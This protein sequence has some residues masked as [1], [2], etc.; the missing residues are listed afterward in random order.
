MNPYSAQAEIQTPTAAYLRNTPVIRRDIQELVEG[1]FLADYLYREGAATPSG[2][3]HY[4]RQLL[5]NVVNT[6]RSVQ[7]VEELT[8]FPIL[9]AEQPAI[10]A[11]YAEKWGGAFLFSYEKQ[12]QDRRDLL[13]D[14][15]IRLRTA[16]LSKCNLVAITTFNNDPDRNTYA[17]AAPWTDKTNGQ[18]IND[19]MQAKV[20]ARNR[21]L[22]YQPDTGI[23]HELDV[24]E[25]LGFD[26]V[27]DRLPREDRSLN[28]FLSQEIN[29]LLGLDWVVAEDDEI[30]RGNVHII[31]RQRA[32]SVHDAKPF[33]SRIVDKPELEGTLIMAGRRT[34]P[35]VTDPKA[36]TTI[37]GVSV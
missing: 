28:P 23:I 19:I 6:T 21:K 32:G 29:G 4:E 31:S 5:E 12:E 33:Y 9:N 20:L 16:V 30:A 25:L 14:A 34:V 7:A 10:E 13:G 22:G 17:A 26:K 36:I 3:V 1:Q 15:L 8:E 2:S 11:A 35:V 37:T 18:P 27:A 24:I